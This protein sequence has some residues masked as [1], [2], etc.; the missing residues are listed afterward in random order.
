MMHVGKKRF[1]ALAAPLAAML[2]Q[3]GVAQATTVLYQ[4][5]FDT[6]TT[7]TVATLA[8][9]SLTN[10]VLSSAT[11]LSGQLRGV[12]HSIHNESLDIG[13]FTGN[14]TFSFDATTLEGG[15]GINVGLRVGDNNYIFHP[16][17]D[18]FGTGTERGGFRI[19]GPGGHANEDMGFTPSTALS[20]MTISVDATTKLTTIDI[21]NPVGT[22]HETFTD[23]NY[24]AGTTVFGL[25]TGG[26]GTAIFD[27]VLVTAVPEPETYAMMLVGLGLIGWQLRRSSKRFAASLLH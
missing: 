11:V 4:Q 14:I 22:F 21:V 16:G 12:V 20:R 13:P 26:D 2:I 8:A 10:N 5:N 23:S 24:V 18:G 1:A 7:T 3:A 15:A 9:Y 19:D 17:Y 27:N 25:T 6:D